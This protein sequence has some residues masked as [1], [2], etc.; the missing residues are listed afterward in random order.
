MSGFDTVS[1]VEDWLDTH[2]DRDEV[3]E[4]LEVEREN[5]GRVTAIEA[6]EDYL[7]STE[8]PGTAFRVEREFDGHEVGETVYLDPQDEE[9]A[10]LRRG[11]EVSIE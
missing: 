11:G 2:P 10:S 1:D 9:T 5:K 8:N 6:L 4:A 7:D 3:E